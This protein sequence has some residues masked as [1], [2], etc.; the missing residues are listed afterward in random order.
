MEK[1][2]K[3][4]KK[5]LYRSNYRGCRETDKIIGGFAKI[6]IDSLTDKELFEFENI[7]EENDNL[8]YKWISKKDSL[9]EKYK[10]S[11]LMQKLITHTTQNY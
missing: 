11:H 9:P 2:L 8:L 5:I 4:K 6:H 1:I 10:N 7:L 3:L